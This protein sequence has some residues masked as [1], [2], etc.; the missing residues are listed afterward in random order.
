MVDGLVDRLRL[1]RPGGRLGALGTSRLSSPLKLGAKKYS[2]PSNF[3][4]PQ[5]GA[6]AAGLWRPYRVGHGCEGEGR[7][8]AAIFSG[9]TGC[10]PS[11]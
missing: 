5:N 7:S 9:G 6:C 1:R 8:V 3:T 2:P 11:N 4:K 10:I